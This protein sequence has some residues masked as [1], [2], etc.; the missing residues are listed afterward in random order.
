MFKKSL[1]FHKQS[2]QGNF[3]E[4]SD[5]AERCIEHFDLLRYQYVVLNRTIAEIWR[6]KA[7]LMRS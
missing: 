5:E 3:G 1:H 2:V 4:D 6:V 7:I